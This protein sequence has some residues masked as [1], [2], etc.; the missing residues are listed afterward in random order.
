M[1]SGF[2]I[3]RLSGTYT[4]LL[5]PDIQS[6]RGDSL[7]VNRNTGLDALR[8]TINPVTGATTVITA[9]STAPVAI[10]AGSTDTPA[11]ITSQITVG[12]AFPI[13][14]LNLRL[15]IAFADP[16]A[17]TTGLTATLITPQ[18]DRIVLFGGVGAVG[19]TPG[20]ADT[21]FDDDA[22]TLIA[23]GGPPYRGRFKPQQPLDRPGTPGSAGALHAGDHQHLGLRRHAQ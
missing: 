11:T 15:N 18:G 8:G 10:P 12:D 5:G 1:R 21:V 17:S 19:G 22:T 20:F 7:D 13:Q 6:A 23:D 2:P 4:I 16:S 9:N 3:Q 14:D